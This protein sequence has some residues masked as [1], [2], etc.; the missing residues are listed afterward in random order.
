MLCAV[1]HILTPGWNLQASAGGRFEMRR[2]WIILPVAAALAVSLTACGA[3]DTDMNADQHYGSNGTAGS[4][5]TIGSAAGSAGPAGT[6]YSAGR[7]SYNRRDGRYQDFIQDG[8]YT[9]YSDGRVA[10]NNGWDLN[11][12]LDRMDDGLRDGMRDF[13][14]DTK[15]AAR[16]LGD[17]IQNA[18]RDF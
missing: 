17:G 11:R 3:R 10:P 5:G 1:F 4:T 9:A 2:N 7:T 8:R 13:W 6:S 15:N 16:D 18:A 14:N 12:E